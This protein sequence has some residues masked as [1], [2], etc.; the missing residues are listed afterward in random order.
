M[1]LC[2]WVKAQVIK[3]PNNRQLVEQTRRPTHDASPGVVSTNTAISIGET[4][5]MIEIEQEDWVKEVLDNSMVGMLNIQFDNLVADEESDLSCCILILV[6]LL[7]S[8][9]H[10]E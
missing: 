4:V 10:H 6:R 7:L 3:L 9:E 2:S 8:N 5:L 1:C